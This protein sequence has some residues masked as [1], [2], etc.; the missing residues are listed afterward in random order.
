MFIFLCIHLFRGILV[1][2]K[3]KQT[4]KTYSFGRV[5]PLQQAMA[6]GP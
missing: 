3:K 2:V 4:D 6:F 1:C 5:N